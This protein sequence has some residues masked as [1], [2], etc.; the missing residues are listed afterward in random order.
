[1][2][3][4][5]LVKLKFPGRPVRVAT[6]CAVRV[7]ILFIAGLGAGRAQDFDRAMFQLLDGST[8]I[9]DCGDC[10][11]PPI[12]H[13]LRGSFEL[14]LLN[15]TPLGSEYA[16]TNLLLTTEGGAPGTI[17]GR[18]T[19]SIGGEVLVLQHL[20]LE[21][22]RDGAL[23]V[24]MENVSLN[25]SKV[26]PLLSLAVLRVDVLP[27]PGS[28]T[29][30]LVAAPARD[31]WFSTINA[32][33]PASSSEP[34]TGGDLV[35]ANG[36]VVQSMSNLVGAL[37][38]PAA[39][40]PV[41]VDAVDIQ[42]GGEVWLSLAADQPVSRFGKLQHGDIV[43][44]RGTIVARNQD[45]TLAFGIMP[46]V[47]DVGLDAMRAEASGEIFF[48]TTT[49]IFS[50]RL[51]RLL[52]R[53]D[54]LSNRGVIVAANEVLL[55]EFQ[56]TSAGDFG[57]DAFYQWPSGEIWFSVERGFQDRALGPVG[58]GDILSSQGIIVRRN[59]DLLSVFAPIEDLADF[60]LDALF[61]VSDLSVATSAP[62]LSRAVWE[63]GAAHIEWQGT[64]RVFQVLRAGSSGGP[65]DAVSPLLPVSSFDDVD[66]PEEA[67]YYRI[68]QW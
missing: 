53:G 1:M 59:L 51:G 19:Y 44:N 20:S 33:T 55:A 37:G 34:L 40:W 36:V 7:A 4:L 13:R 10:A 54:L 11:Q 15:S 41:Q 35:S 21:I 60:G 42:P 66:G 47:P 27:L 28:L 50:E 58:A 30:N 32:F 64:G 12:I 29:L 65:Y 52:R 68:R 25:V 23:P 38:L 56:P 8:L 45:L 6:W 61:V 46:A 2:N 43:S 31:I 22:S 62:R 39:S 67:G 49:E 16:V 3:K 24:R 57:L 48:S 14:V 9:E 26:F 5:R 63:R 18:G 17:T